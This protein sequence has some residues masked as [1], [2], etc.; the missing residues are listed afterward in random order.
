M[1]DVNVQPIAPATQPESGLRWFSAIPT[2]IVLVAGALTVVGALAFAWLV[3]WLLLLSL[4]SFL[5]GPDS[6]LDPLTISAPVAFVPPALATIV[7][8]FLV[9]R[10]LPPLSEWRMRLLVWERDAA[11]QSSFDPSV[12]LTVGLLVV[13][14]VGFVAYE[15]LVYMFHRIHG[16]ID[17]GLYL[18]AGRMVMSGNLPYRDFYYD[19]APLLPF[20]FGLALAPF[21][22]NEVAARL[23][24]MSCTALTLLLAFWTATR[25][26]G[27]LA[28][29]IAFALLVTNLDFLP[30]VSAGVTA[31]GSLT[32]LVAVLAVLALSYDQLALALLLACV[33][34]GL[35]Q[36]FIPLPIVIAVYVAVVRRRPWEALLL[37]LVPFLAVYLGFL[38]FGGPAAPYGMIPPLRA[39]FVARDAS[40]L[41]FHYE[42][43]SFRDQAMHVFTAYLPF[44]LCA[45]PLAFLMFRRGHP[46]GRLL[47]VIATACALILLANIFP[48]IGNPRY[49]VSQLP[50]VAILGGVA[51][52]TVLRRADP[53]T[54]R[55]ALA[56]GLAMLVAAAPLLA[57]RDSTFIDEFH[58][59][60]PLAR[61]LAASDYVR[62]IAPP[63][64]TLLTLET[65]FATQTGLRLP[66][67]LEAGSWGVY[68]GISDDQAKRL[69]VVTYKMLADMVEAGAG[70]IVIESDHYGMVK[71]YIQ[72]DDQKARMEEGL[73]KNYELK[74]TFGQVSDWGDVRVWVR[75]Q[76]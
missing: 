76:S 22:Y 43:L 71:N 45:G 37:G 72:N 50:L 53:A 47:A 73:K 15:R 55:P 20:A 12:P 56:A 48:Y 31:N 42:L 18:Y 75:K 60:P 40:P 2:A 61:F 44:W 46:H 32:A 57:F 39:P 25:L 28:G 19:Q 49:P 67:G 13:G 24:A 30:E 62:S 38:A 11:P 52:A 8:M 58:T 74:E 26:G 63:N 9:W 1:A 35:R 3:V 7:T 29:L 4:G 23:F 27:R 16:A 59:K 6:P 36:V 5:L 70:D 14:Y 21:Q 65:P 66:H 10:R 34:A 17:E 69:N 41:G 51:A 64:A 33:A 54:A 68:K